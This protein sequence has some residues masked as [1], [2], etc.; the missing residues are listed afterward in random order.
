MQSYLEKVINQ[1]FIALL[2]IILLSLLFM[3]I[4]GG[5]FPGSAFDSQCIK[6]HFDSPVIFFLPTDR[7]RV[8][9]QTTYDKA[10]VNKSMGALQVEWQRDPKKD[11]GV[12]TTAYNMDRMIKISFL[13]RSATT[14]PLKLELR[15]QDGEHRYL[16]EVQLTPKWKKY[17]F[18]TKDFIKFN[19]D[20][21]VSGESVAEN[22]TAYLELS[23]PAK[24]SQQSGKFWIDEIEIDSF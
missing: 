5:I 23:I 11:V 12:Y 14:V 6:Q 16:A 21:E 24:F 7:S 17:E 3:T 9:E 20:V 19:G 18:S 2:V 22:L 4:N 1:S 8:Y 15:S 13:A 10:L